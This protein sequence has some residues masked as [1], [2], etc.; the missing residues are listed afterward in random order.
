MNHIASRE[1]T[2][3]KPLT[4]RA[5]AKL[6]TRQTLLASARL[7]FGERGYEAATVRDI[8]SAAGLSTG[9]VFANFN[10]KA[11]LFTEIL[12]ADDEQVIAKMGL[13]AQAALG[14]RA[15]VLAVLSAGYEFHLGQLPLFQASQGAAWSR[16]PL[17]EAVTGAGSRRVRFLVEQA[18]QKG[19][20][21]GELRADLDVALAADLIWQ[22]YL[23]NYRLAVHEG[24]DKEALISRLRRQLDLVLQ[25][26]T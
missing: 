6:K 4:R 9:A 24:A 3:A 19:I 12:A 17:S 10:D 21:D 16:G 7:L 13:A 22:A 11:D 23:S 5:L 18:L 14:V 15:V 20:A 26:N 1:L 2:D 25:T 8:A